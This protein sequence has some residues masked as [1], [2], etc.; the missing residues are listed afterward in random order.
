MTP[1]EIELLVE[2]KVRQTLAQLLGPLVSQQPQPQAEWLDL[3]DAFAL[4]GLPSVKALRD[5][6]RDGLL[7]TG[8][9]VRDRRKPGAKHA[10][11]QVN[12]A[13]SQVR[14]NSTP[15]KRRPV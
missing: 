3:K 8:H 15:N 5:A 11:Y 14:L 7:R 6:I 2:L 1:H 9:E 4:L 12:L 13:L 10:R